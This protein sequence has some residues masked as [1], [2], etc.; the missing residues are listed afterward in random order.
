MPFTIIP[1]KPI[2]RNAPFQAENQKK[3]V[4]KNKLIRKARSKINQ[5]FKYFF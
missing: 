2:I 4:H 1:G 3:P 5:I